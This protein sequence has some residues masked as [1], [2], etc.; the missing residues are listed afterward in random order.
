MNDITVEVSGEQEEFIER[1]VQ[2]L[3]KFQRELDEADARTLQVIGLVQEEGKKK[4]T[5]EDIRYSLEYHSRRVRGEEWNGAVTRLTKE[6]NCRVDEHFKLQPPV[7]ES[8]VEFGTVSD[9]KS[10]LAL[11]HLNLH[12]RENDVVPVKF[13]L[14]SQDPEQRATFRLIGQLV[15]RL[16]DI[17]REYQRIGAVRVRPGLPVL[18]SGLRDEKEVR[19]E[20]E[21]MKQQRAD[22]R[23]LDD[24][25]YAALLHI[26]VKTDEL[27]AKIRRL[28]DEECDIRIEICMY[29]LQGNRFLF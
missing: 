9:A 25:F 20:L 15:A 27:N 29:R 3:H 17:E 21:Q 12:V 7:A 14:P 10:V 5:A 18:A 22:G 26:Q 19:V 6:T 2:T 23:S 4:V 24:T 13:I 8:F 1:T 28:Y 11:R 16:R